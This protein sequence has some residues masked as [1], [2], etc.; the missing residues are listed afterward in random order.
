MAYA[1]ARGIE[2]IP[3]IDMPGH[4]LSAIACYPWLGCGAN[5][6]WADFSS[7]LCLGN[8]RVLQFCRDVWTEL[9]NLFP[10]PYVHIG[11]DEV[12]MVFWKNC[13]RCQ[14]RMKSNRLADGHALQ[15]WFTNNMQ[16]FFTAHGNV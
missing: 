13:P 7:P 15:A 9:F 11:G 3:E 1:Q 14:A 2:V 8:D 4:S 10:S 6:Q 12:D 16:A 5:N